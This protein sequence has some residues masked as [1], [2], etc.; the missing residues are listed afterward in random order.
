[1]RVTVLRPRNRTSGLNFDFPIGIANPTSTPMCLGIDRTAGTHLS[2]PAIQPIVHAP[3]YNHHPPLFDFAVH[4]SDRA[5][6]KYRADFFAL[7]DNHEGQPQECGLAL[8]RRKRLSKKIDVLLDAS[9][10]GV[11]DNMVAIPRI[12]FARDYLLPS[13]KNQAENI[14]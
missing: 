1:V 13:R 12:I 2:A 6:V 14:R 5:G 8:S 9:V 7:L 3:R 10:R 11:N 4:R